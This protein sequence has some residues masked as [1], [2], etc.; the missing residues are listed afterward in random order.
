MARQYGEGFEQPFDFQTGKRDDSAP[1]VG[2][3]GNNPYN[4]GRV[5]LEPLPGEKEPDR[6]P[7]AGAANA[8]ISL[9]PLVRDWDGD[10]M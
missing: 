1:L 5:Q 4:R 2:Y 6:R 9:P 7:P 10:G 8:T 3:I